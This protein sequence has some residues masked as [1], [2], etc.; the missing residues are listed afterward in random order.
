MPDTTASE[1]R[2]SAEDTLPLFPQPSATSRRR[3]GPS[4]EEAALTLKLRAQVLRMRPITTA[5]GWSRTTTRRV[6]EREGAA[7]PAP[8]PASSGRPSKL[9]PFREAIAEKVPQ[10]HRQ[11]GAQWYEPR[12]LLLAS[13]TCPSSRGLILWSIGK[14][15]WRGGYAQIAS[16]LTGPGNRWVHA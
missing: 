12:L 1:P 10:D 4:T 6:L 13:L 5:L 8:R 16:G 15:E 2:P 3:D 14:Q 9:D 11:W 7:S